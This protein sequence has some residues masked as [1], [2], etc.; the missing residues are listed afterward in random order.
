MK[1][2]EEKKERKFDKQFFKKAFR[3]FR[4]I[5][6][7]K[8]LF[9]IGLACLFASSLTTLAFPL[10]L[11]KLFDSKGGGNINVLALALLGIFLINAFF[12]YFRIV[13]FENVAQ[14][15]LDL[16]RRSTY[17]HLI[18]LPMSF[19]SS[20]R[21]GEL[22]SRISS[23]IS[24]LQT[25]FTTTSA[26]FLRQILTILGGITLLITISLKLTL[27]MLG[28]V[29]II[30]VVAIISGNSFENY[31]SKL[32]MPWRIRTPLLKK[33]FRESAA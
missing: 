28:I 23:D 32:K 30:S 9:F 11:G 22:N 7:Y 16:L 25:T 18:R 21:V 3:L 14:K 6:P 10:L 15:S 5:A 29:P 1:V 12:S 13:L 4:F 31:P 27:F 8:F 2:E 24:L 33:R 26:E 19:F 17:D 20:R